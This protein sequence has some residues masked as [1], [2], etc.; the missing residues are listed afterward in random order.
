MK[1]LDRVVLKFNKFQIV[2]VVLKAGR[3]KLL[4]VGN[5]T[6]FLKCNCE[7]VI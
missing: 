6:F 7:M 1:W 5:R 2:G 3:C 4:I